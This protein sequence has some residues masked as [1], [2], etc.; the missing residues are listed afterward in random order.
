MQI[1]KNNTFNQSQNIILAMRNQDAL[2]LFGVALL[3]LLATFPFLNNPGL[4]D[5][6]DAEL[7]IFRI[8]E[9]G[10]SIQQGVLYPRWAP[11]FYHGFGYPIFNYYAPFSYHLGYYLSLGTPE[12]AARSAKVLFIVSIFL[13]AYGAYF[14]GKNHSNR[15]GG[16]LGSAAY[17][18][19]PYI[20]LINPHSRGDL[21]EVVALAFLPWAIHYWTLLWQQPRKKTMLLTVLF[22][23][24]TLL[25][26]NL[27]GLVLL[28]FIFTL[29]IWEWFVAQN[30]H[31]T[32]WLIGV[33]LVF[34][35]I[36]SF[37]WLPFLVERNDILLD[38][39]GDGH[40]DF[41]NHYIRL[42]ELLSFT[43]KFDYRDTTMQIPFSAGPFFVILAIVGSI[44]SLLIRK[45]GMIF[46]IL[47]SLLFFFL[48]TPLSVFIW[49][50]IPGLAYFQFP[51]RFLGPL[52][53]SMVP[54]IA[55]CFSTLSIVSHNR[56]SPVVEAIIKVAVIGVIITISL[57]ALYPIPWV[58][59]FNRITKS[60]IIQAEL[61]GRWRGTTSTND[62]VPATVD[63]VPSPFQPLI[64]SYSHPPIDR[65][66][67]FTIP[68]GTT[69]TVLDDQPNHFFVAAEE[70]YVLRL[71]LFDFPGWRAYVDN[72]PYP[73]ELAHPEGFITVELPPGDHDV[74]LRFEDSAIRTI[75]WWISAVGFMLGVGGLVFSNPPGKSQLTIENTQ[76][77]NNNASI[78]PILTGVICIF[79]GVNSL[80]I[81]P[82]Q[83][84]SYKSDLNEALSAD[85]QVYAE[86][87]QQIALLGYDIK[88]PKHRPGQTFD[89]QLYW[90]AVKPISRTYQSFIHIMQP[91]GQILAQSDHLNP[92]GHPTNLWS[93]DRY[94]RDNHTLTIPDYT[95]PGEYKINV[96][97]YSLR[98]D[99]RLD[100]I[101]PYTGEFVSYVTL[102][103]SVIIGR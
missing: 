79:L 56:L 38:V 84:M 17:C 46:Y 55:S 9:M 83:M 71:M 100:T 85:Y 53:I 63:M 101:D 82:G 59:G 27:T 36:T 90:Q 99:I 41:H 19:S 98:D 81:N 60:A 48:I 95:V 18:F 33:G 43:R 47:L 72:V 91:N 103:E 92:G 44:S 29:A 35:L 34:V 65:V 76:H 88:D 2:A 7:H 5:M 62:F 52:A 30:R 87:G 58:S 74:L 102:E 31:H 89:I 64:D 61:Q 68:E 25:S 23:S 42:R 40:Y 49:E 57:P 39:A 1:K 22:S 75:S 12:N 3:A 15:G 10:F 14:L 4:P 8:A 66:N 70:P 54:L 51:W 67:R 6:T 21:A 24:A 11:D 69:V 16:L 93:T 20:Q 86:F 28:G 77:E 80:L 26:H 97:I 94:I 45:R 13:G 96:G 73:I 78:I 50:I 32:K 37:F